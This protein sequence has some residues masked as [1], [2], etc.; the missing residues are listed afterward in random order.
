MPLKNPDL[1]VTQYIEN[2]E[3][4]AKPILTHL[5][6]QIHKNCPDVVESIKWGIPHFNYK[7]D[8]MCVLAS[9]KNHCSLTFIK[10]EFM[11]DPRFTGGKK[12]KASERFMGRLKSFSDLPSDGELASFI[13]EAM[14][15]NDRGVKLEQTA[16]A[17]PNSTPV[18]TPKYFIE[19]LSAN[20]AA[21]EVF[22]SQSASFRKNYI[23][24]FE[25]AKTEATRQ[26]RIDEALG[27]IAEGKGRFWKYQK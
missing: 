1:K 20:P 12:V 15:L 24:W 9:A 6:E 4:F 19:A 14:D 16:K 18:E 2:A 25:S 17:K 11:S 27:W 3:D 7:N 23:I 13:K 5:R 21:K 26:Q 22:E 10:S 8:Y